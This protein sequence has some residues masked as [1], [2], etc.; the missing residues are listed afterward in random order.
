MHR[1]GDGTYEICNLGGKLRAVAD[2]RNLTDD[3]AADDNS[4]CKTCHGGGLL[5]IRDSESHSH[6]HLCECPD[7]GDTFSDIG[8]EAGLLTGDSFSGNII[9][10]TFGGISDLFEA[11]WWRRRGNQ[12]D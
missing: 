1:L 10:E 8:R 11:L 6:G 2:L 7:G 12:T 9:D 4:I 5:W 3:G